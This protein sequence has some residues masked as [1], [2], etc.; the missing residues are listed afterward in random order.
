[1]WAEAVTIPVIPPPATPTQGIRRL[2]LRALEDDPQKEE[3]LRDRGKPRPVLVSIR[4]TEQS[5][6]WKA[7]GW[8]PY[9]K[10]IGGQEKIFEVSGPTLRMVLSMT[11]RWVSRN[12]DKVRIAK[13]V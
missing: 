9:K 13:G 12:Q 1:M 4:I 10:Q 8:G 11:S 2:I 6:T 7:V 5:G 3:T